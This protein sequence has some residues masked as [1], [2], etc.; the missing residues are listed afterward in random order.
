MNYSIQPTSELS[1]IRL[2]PHNKEVT[3]IIKT[4]FIRQ[5]VI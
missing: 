4:K 2:K 3:L 1:P 5:H